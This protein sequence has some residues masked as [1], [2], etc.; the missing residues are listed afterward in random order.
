[1]VWFWT[2]ISIYIFVC[3]RPYENLIELVWIRLNRW[4]GYN[5]IR[6]WIFTHARTLFR[7]LNNPLKVMSKLNMGRDPSPSCSLR[8]SFIYC[9]FPIFFF[10]VIWKMNNYLF[11]E[12]LNEYMIDLPFNG[13][14]L[15]PEQQQLWV[16]STNFIRAL[17]SK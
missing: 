5:S 17:Y 3:L 4:F 2:A 6:L 14:R 12:N 8:S 13:A 15:R 9:N 1:M 16:Q 10:F 7:P 11:K